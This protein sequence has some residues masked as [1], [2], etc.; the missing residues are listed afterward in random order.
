MRAEGTRPLAL[1]A[2]LL[3]AVLIL[4]AAPTGLPAQPSAAQEIPTCTSQV[5]SRVAEER[6]R[7][8]T[9][10]VEVAWLVSVGARP[11]APAG[12]VRR[13]MSVVSAHLDTVSPHQQAEVLDGIDYVADDAGT[14]L[15]LRALEK[16]S[17]IVRRKASQVLLRTARGWFR[18]PEMPAL[19][20]S[21]PVFRASQDVDPEVRHASACVLA[22]VMWSTE[23]AL[24]G[25]STPPSVGTARARALVSRIRNAVPAASRTDC[26]G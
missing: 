17:V 25:L 6:T 3:C 22:L 14:E 26:I 20:S 19:L 21:E 7:G 8:M 4:P 18:A 10:L 2:R 5:E 11:K 1:P 23:D 16:P 12:T 13:L 24:A 9:C 15:L